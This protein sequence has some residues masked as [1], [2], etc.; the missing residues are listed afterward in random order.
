MSRQCADEPIVDAERLAEVTTDRRRLLRELREPLHRSR[1]P[2]TPPRVFAALYQREPDERNVAAVQRAYRAEAGRY[3]ARSDPG[4]VYVFRD[5]RDAPGIV[6]IGRTRQR[7]EARHTQWRSELADSSADAAQSR[8]VLLF[9]FA[10]RRQHLAERVVH[11]LLHCSHVAGRVSRTT[12]RDLVEYF[13]TDS[14]V[15]LRA[16]VDAVTR[17]TIW[18]DA[19]LRR[20]RL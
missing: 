1:E 18:F 9:A 16:L 19:A 12:G 10:T 17:H 15:L 2:M 7:V 5:L 4:F 14:L 8:V 6:K 11:A 3:A 13:R 20:R